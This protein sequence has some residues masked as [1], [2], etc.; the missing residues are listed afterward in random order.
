MWLALL[1][2]VVVLLVPVMLVVQLVCLLLSLML[3][4][5]AVEPIGSFRLSE[6][7]HSGACEAGEQLF[8]K[9]MVDFLAFQ[10]ISQR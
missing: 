5:L 4:L 10:N 6:P 9:A 7:V 1:V 3:R 8:G 2:W